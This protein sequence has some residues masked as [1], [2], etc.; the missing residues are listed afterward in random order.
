LSEKNDLSEKM[1]GKAANLKRKLEAWLAESK[2]AMPKP[3]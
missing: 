3:V 1:P 2:A